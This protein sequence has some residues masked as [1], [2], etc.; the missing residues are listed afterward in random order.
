MIYPNS[1][2]GLP[3]SYCSQSY[4]NAFDVDAPIDASTFYEEAPSILPYGTMF[5]DPFFATPYNQD[6]F[7]PALNDAAISNYTA[8]TIAYNTGSN[9][10]IF[11]QP[12]TPSAAVIENYIEPN[13]VL[14]VTPFQTLTV[15]AEMPVNTIKPSQ[16]STQVTPS[17]NA[18]STNYIVPIVIVGAIGIWL[19]FRKKSKK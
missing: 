2:L 6:V 1:H 17:A 19:L 13:Q 15:G 7:L 14:P 5:Q 4:C 18:Q 8:D 12:V 3:Q 11:V 16:V 10:E 9:S